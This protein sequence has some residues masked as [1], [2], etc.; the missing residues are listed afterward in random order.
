MMHLRGKLEGP[1]SVCGRGRK[2]NAVVALVKLGVIWADE[3]IS[4]NPQRSHRGWDIETDKSTEADGLT[5]FRDGKHVLSTSQCK[6]F[7]AQGKC[8]HRQGRNLAAVNSVL[9]CSQRRGSDGLVE[10]GDLRGGSSDERGTGVSDGLAASLAELLRSSHRHTVH[11]DLPVP[12]FGDWQ[13]GEVARVF[14]GVTASQDQLSSLRCLGVS[15]KVEGESWLGDQALRYSVVERGH[16]SVHRDGLVA[17]SQD[18]V[19]LRGNEGD[20]RLL[21]GLSEGLLLNLHAADS[22]GVGA[23]ESSQTASA[24]LDGEDGAVSNVGVGLSAVVFVVKQAGDIGE[25]A[26]LRGHP[27]VGRAGVKH[28]LEVLL[29]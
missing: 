20:A 21:G 22:E 7:A 8:D 10:S 23:E 18:S 14:L 28:H 12:L 9:S 15:V 6:L 4:Q 13:V 5:E 11:L 27:Q 3:N 26:F 1:G 16:D 19:K 29:W 2:T 17:Q 24:I 25:L